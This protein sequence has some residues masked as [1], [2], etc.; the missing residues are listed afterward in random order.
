MEQQET[1]VEER[2]QSHLTLVEETLR[3]LSAEER[4]A[5]EAADSALRQQLETALDATGEQFQSALGDMEMKL[6]GRGEADLEVIARAQTE[7][8]QQVREECKAREIA[9][10]ELMHLVRDL[11]VCILPT[12]RS[13][14]VV[15]L[16]DETS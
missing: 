1:G 12:S 10:A 8:E 4:C 6:Q 14:A 15:F 11:Q 2:L 5:R 7:L 9:D 3:A 16:S 13:I